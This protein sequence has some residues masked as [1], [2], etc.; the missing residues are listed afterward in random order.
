MPLR[1][2]LSV[3]SGIL[4]ALAF[5]NVGAGWLVFVALAAALRR[6]RQA[7]GG[8]RVGVLSAGSRRPTAWLVMV[9]WVVRVMSHYGGLPYVTGVLLFIAMCLVP[10]PVRRAFSACSS[11]AS[12]LAT[13]FGRG[14]SSRW[15]G[16]R[17]SMRARTCSPAF[18]GISS[19]R[20]SSTT[21]RSSSSTAL[22]GPYLLGALILLPSTLARLAHLPSGPAQGHRATAGHR[23][24]RRSSASSGGRPAGR[25]EAHRASGRRR[26]LRVRRCCSRTS[27]RRCAG[28]RRTC[29]PSTAG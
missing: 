17:S 10:R 21:R 23:R 25:G 29:W 4:F 27:R 1:I 18:R 20:R 12:G 15:R 28:T 3:I 2:A 24:R 7:R 8:W 26:R 14:C 19:P 5:P 16:R 11:G 13:S 22:A 6:T 9:P